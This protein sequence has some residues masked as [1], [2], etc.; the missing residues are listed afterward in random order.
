MRLD[1]AIH[2]LSLRSRK[3]RGNGRK[4]EVREKGRKMER[5]VWKK[6]ARNE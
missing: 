2:I 4:Q 5:E 6:E 3:V 1:L